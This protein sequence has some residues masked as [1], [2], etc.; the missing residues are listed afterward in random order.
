VQA[1]PG[2]A[3]RAQRLL[4]DLHERSENPDAL[5]TGFEIDTDLRDLVGGYRRY[6]S[7]D[8]EAVWRAQNA[9]VEALAMRLTRLGPGLGT[10]R[11]EELIGQA[12]LIT[13]G[14][15]ARWVAEAM[16]LHLD[17]PAAWYGAAAE[18]PSPLLLSVALTRWLQHALSTVPAD[19]LID[20][21]QDQSFRAV[22][23]SVIVERTDLDATAEIV[24][25]DLRAE[26]TPSLSRL[27]A[28]SD[29]DDVLHRLLVHAVAAISGTAALSFAVA[30]PFGPPLPEHWIPEWRDAV[31]HLRVQDV[32]DSFEWRISELLEHLA[33]HDPDLFERWFAERLDEQRERDFLTVPEPHGCEH[34]LAR[35]PRPHRQ[36]LA[37]RC[38]DQSR[39][40]QSLLTHLLGHDREL[41]E[42]LLDEES[43][44]R[45]HLLEAIAGQRNTI[46]EQLGPL[47]LERGVP[48]ERIAASAGAPFGF[49]WGEDSGR[50]LSTLKYFDDLAERVPD[51]LPVA[52][53]GHNQQQALYEQAVARE[54]HHRI[55]GL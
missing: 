2:L 53:A 45:D 47:L 24:I 48:P 6:R 55:R 19:T 43:A 26:D 31:A 15:K 40:G 21:L 37:V 9:A 14:T 49:A 38:T 36:R 12:R 13:L 52:Q 1:V 46:L 28:R 29:A 25:A 32:G 33:E 51:L 34:H 11:F 44:T 23:V 41:A 22:V 39:G 27:T 3:L 10:A 18:A 17:D 35:L 54:R 42:Q 50:H 4:D 30:Q 16:Q 7:N 5:P 20:A 8:G